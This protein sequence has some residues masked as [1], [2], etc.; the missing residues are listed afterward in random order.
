MNGRKILLGVTG[1]VGAFKAAALASKLVQEGFDVRTVMTEGAKKF[2]GE[3]TFEGLTRNRVYSD[4]YASGDAMAHIDLARWADLTLIYPTSANSITKFSQGRADDLLGTLFLA[5]DFKRP[6]WIVPAMN[7]AMFAHPAVREAIDKLR[8]W[9]VDVVE[10][11]DGRMACGEVGPGRL[12]EPETMLEK[13]QTHFSISASLGKHVLVTA[14]GTSEA[15]DPVR[16]L[17]NVSTG[18]TGVRVANALAD[19]GKRVTLLLANSS[20]FRGM[21]ASGVRVLSYRTFEE[22]DSAMKAEL[23]AGD[24]TTLI[25]A[26]AVSDFRVAEI[27]TEDGTLLP[28]A[29]KIQSK[30]PLVL[31]LIPNHKILGRVREYSKNK[32]LQVISFKLATPTDSRARADLS[33]YDSDVIVH[34]ITSGIER[35]SDR[36]AGEIFERTPEGYRVHSTF[37]TKT[38]LARAITEVVLP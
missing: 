25:H 27:K 37:Q 33:G 23:S 35:G 24:Y 14:G 15:I 30:D 18:E 5:H 19:A 7:P 10:A 31:R 26:A 38:D 8:G 21:V 28:G 13:I 9:G 20:P 1:S 22:L 2:I 4:L 29:V 34:N 16:I 6:Y 32:A 12:V 11:A 36:H 3:S 17:T